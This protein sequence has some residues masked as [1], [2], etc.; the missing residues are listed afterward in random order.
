M[1]HSSHPPVP[2]ILLQSGIHS[3][4]AVPIDG[5]ANNRPDDAVINIGDW[6]P[7][8]RLRS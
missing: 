1:L 4:V 8:L 2:I 3:A 6:V 7:V 5:A